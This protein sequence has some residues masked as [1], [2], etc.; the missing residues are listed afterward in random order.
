MSVALGIH[1]VFLALMVPWRIL[2]SF[3]T[4]KAS[5]VELERYLEDT[6]TDAKRHEPMSVPSDIPP[7][8]PPEYQMEV[9]APKWKE[10]EQAVR[11]ARASSSLGPNGVPYRVYKSA[12]GVLQILCKL[13][14]VAW[15]K[16]VV[17]RAWRRA[18]GV[19]IHKE[20]DATSISQFCPKIFLTI[21]AQSLSTYLLTNG[22]IKH[23]SSKS[24]F[25]GC[26]NVVTIPKLLFRY[27]YQVKNWDFDTFPEKEK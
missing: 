22:L 2:I 16:L 11:K 12:S 5:R 6:H 21:I 10:V 7:I 26:L 24:G 14:K 23:F 3:K 1:T 9:C 15:E 27:Q 8:N 13:M 17:P 19:F 18:S 4:F 25:S 20:K